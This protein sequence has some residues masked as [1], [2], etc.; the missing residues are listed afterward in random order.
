MMRAGRR[1]LDFLASQ[2]DYCESGKTKDLR[3][4]RQ[5]KQLPRKGF[6]GQMKEKRRV[7]IHW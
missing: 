1:L 2:W 7:T 5:G 4:E 6:Q 3:H